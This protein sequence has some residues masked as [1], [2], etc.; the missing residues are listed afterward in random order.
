MSG[1]ESTVEDA[2]IDRGFT[3]QLVDS[4][5]VPKPDE[6]SVRYSA[7]RSWDFVRY[8]SDADIRIY[9]GNILVAHGHYHH[10]GRSL[11]LDI[12]TK[13]RSVEWKMEDLYDELFKNYTAPQ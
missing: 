5:Y 10:V 12:F 13:W 7:R 8:L 9:K 3:V 6:Y 4:V 11:S 2:F 1:F